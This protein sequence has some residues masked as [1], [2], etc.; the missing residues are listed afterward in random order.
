[1]PP[2]APVTKT[3]LSCFVIARLVL[4]SS[5]KLRS[6]PRKRASSSWPKHWVPA[7]AGTSGWVS[8]DQSSVLDSGRLDD[9]A[10][11]IDLALEKDRELGRR[12]A[13]DGRAELR[14]A[15]LHGRMVERHHR[16]VMQ[17]ADDL[18][19]YLRGDEER[20]PRGDIVAR[21]EFGDGRQV[22]H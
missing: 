2:A 7:F 3:T 13:D 15:L 16:I 17:L 12:R 1:M 19:R 4:R 9:R 21:N 20:D 22:R 6:C 5:N 11:A 14:V 18:G 10:P 8:P